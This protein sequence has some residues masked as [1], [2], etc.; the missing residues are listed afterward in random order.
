MLKKLKP[1]SGV[2]M[3][4]L[5]IVL[6]IMGILA[7]TVIPMY[8]K[9]QSKSQ[10]NR[11]KS[12]M[13]IIQ[14]AFVNY[15]YYTYSIGSPHYPPSPDSLMTDEWCDTPM[16][17]TINLQTPNE[18]FGTGSVPKNSNNIPFMYKS[19]IDTESDGRQKRKILIKDTD[20]DSPSHEE[21]L[22]FTI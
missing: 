22:L 8:S 13:Q 21:F 16:D 11:N 19:W 7:V 15:Y 18:L 10:F 17:S 5:V 9:L 3:V 2:T 6:A 1:N 14:E 4:E 20:P 12:N